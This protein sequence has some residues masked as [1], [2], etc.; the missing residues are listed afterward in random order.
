VTSDDMYM[1]AY[2]GIQ[3][4]LDVAL[5]PN[6]EDGAGAG[7][8]A[9]VRLLAHRYHLALKAI[10]S[11]GGTVTAAQIR[12]AQLPDPSEGLAE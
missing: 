8:V 12:S 2:F 3:N 11:V 1:T 7:I 9:D 10:E 5:G 6:E 4:V